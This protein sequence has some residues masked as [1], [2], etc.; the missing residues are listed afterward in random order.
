M[1]QYTKKGLLNGYK[2][3]NTE[4]AA[5]DYYA[6]PA[7]EVENIL[8]TLYEYFGYNFTAATLLEPCVGGGHMADGI[9]KYLSAHN[10]HPKEKIAEDYIDRRCLRV[11]VV[12]KKSFKMTRPAMS[13]NIVSVF[14][15]GK[16]VRNQPAPQHK[17]IVGWFGIKI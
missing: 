5:Y 2:K 8:N 15:A 14:N 4:R 6:T 16:M 11:Q 17:P 9:D 7:V 12:G 10:Q 1:G 13:S 3:N